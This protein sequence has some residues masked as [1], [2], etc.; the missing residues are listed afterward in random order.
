MRT[1]LLVSSVVTNSRCHITSVLAELHWLP[2]SAI[3]EYKLAL[4]T[5]KAMTTEKQIYL[6]ELLKLYKPVRQLRSSSPC[7]LHDDGAKTVVGSRAFC[8]AAPTV[9]NALPSSLT[10][11]FQTISLTVLNVIS[12]LIF[13][14]NLLYC[15]SRD[16]TAPAIS[17]NQFIM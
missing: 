7:S 17:S 14:K 13:I 1:V 11:E 5:Y 16:W 6:N 12:R 8:H 4:L 15:R 9:W 3:I 2:V 10:D